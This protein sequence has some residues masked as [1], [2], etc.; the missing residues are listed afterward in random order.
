[1]T[2]LQR[3]EPQISRL[4]GYTVSLV[5]SSG[6]PLARMFN[7]DLSD[8]RCH[9][10]DCTVCQLHKGKGSSK[11]KR[12]SVVYKSSCLWCEKSGSQDGVY[13]GETGRSLYERSLEHLSD[14]K[15]M[16][17]GS[18]IFKHWAISHSSSLTQ[19][20]FMF[21]VLKTHVSSLDR[22]VHEAVKISTDG[23]LNSRCEFRQN[24]VR[25]ISVH[26]TAK[27]LQAAERE[28]AKGDEAMQLAVRDLEKKLSCSLSSNTNLSNVSSVISN[29]VTP[30]NLCSSLISL[31]TTASQYIEDQENPFTDLS[32]KRSLE[33]DSVN[34]QKTKKL[35]ADYPDSSLCSTMGKSRSSNGNSKN[36]SKNLWKSFPRWHEDEFNF[37]EVLRNTPSNR[38]AKTPS[39]FA[40]ASL[41]AKKRHEE[42]NSARLL[43]PTP[44]KTLQQLSPRNIFGANLDS[45]VPSCWSLT[46]TGSCDSS[47]AISSSESPE[48]NGSIFSYIGKSPEGDLSRR[49]L[50]LT[51]ERRSESDDSF[52]SR[53]DTLHNKG[54]LD[55]LKLLEEF[56]AK[57]ES[58]NAQAASFA[59]L[60]VQM[61]DLNVSN[62]ATT[63]QQ[64]PALLNERGWNCQAVSQ[65]WSVAPATTYRQSWDE[66]SLERL[67]GKGV[68]N[69]VWNKLKDAHLTGYAKRPSTESSPTSKRLKVSHRSNVCPAL[70]SLNELKTND[71]CNA[72]EPELTH[73]VKDTPKHQGQKRRKN[74]KSKV[75]PAG[76]ITNWLLN[77]SDSATP[78]KSPSPASNKKLSRRAQ[79]SSA[80]ARAGCRPVLPSP[81]AQS[82]RPPAM[83][84]QVSSPDYVDPT[85][86]RH[87]RRPAKKLRRSLQS[88]PPVP[89]IPKIL[90]SLASEDA[91]ISEQRCTEQHLL[92]AQ[93]SPAKQLT[94][95]GNGMF[96]P[97]STPNSKQ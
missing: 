93:P 16:K 22:Q 11:C 77:M 84:A 36:E 32:S 81:R 6:T 56:Y 25:R 24:Q 47:L 30:S 23:S 60:V 97:A 48:S 54:A 45:P 70:S 18:H 53:P 33:E 83:S 39:T 35:R 68:C 2:S 80:T 67:G 72:N 12:R 92:S 34:P 63:L 46:A 13:I 73:S 55:F 26:L 69:N 51:I 88:K 38:R 37:L 82:Q 44:K 10:A 87:P 14:A 78:K 71:S 41:L 19:P 15:N 75:D 76:R 49:L 7:L 58:A 91:H 85:P 1:M 64:I 90:S 86:A 4:C 94:A 40:E 27:E 50:S 52:S 66:K 20:P 21:S 42:R 61:L 62:K 29:P 28:A 65:V 3:K 89:A 79:E 9:R 31:A 59:D 8:G 74:K 96:Q 57:R 5:E 95:T 17:S 43:A